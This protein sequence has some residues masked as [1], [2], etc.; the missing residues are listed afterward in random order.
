VWTLKPSDVD[1]ALDRL[2]AG[3]LD[4]RAYGHMFRPV[5]AWYVPRGRGAVMQRLRCAGCGSERRL[6]LARDGDVTASRYDYPDGYLIKGMGRLTGSDRG[7]LRL[8][9]LAGLPVRQG[10]PDE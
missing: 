9:G 5:D 8:A 4:C 1:A 6:A 10:P 3:A 2:P 7:R